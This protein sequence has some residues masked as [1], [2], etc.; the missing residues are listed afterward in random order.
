MNFFVLEER[1]EKKK[2]LQ[3]KSLSYIT[4]HHTSHFIVFVFSVQFYHE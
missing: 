3:M 4:L 1:E 2:L